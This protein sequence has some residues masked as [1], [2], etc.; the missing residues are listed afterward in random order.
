MRVSAPVAHSQDS[1]LAC[2]KRRVFALGLASI[3][4]LI[5]R[6]H[7]PVALHIRQT[8]RIRTAWIVSTLVRTPFLSPLYP[9]CVKDRGV[10]STKMPLVTR[11][12]VAE[13]V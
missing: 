12:P 2:R 1:A 5:A 11:R 6:S 4:E 9:A 10:K 7:N 3:F 13:I 8:S